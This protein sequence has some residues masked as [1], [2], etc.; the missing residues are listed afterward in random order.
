GRAM[1]TF[2][3]SFQIGA[4][5]GAIISGAL[6]DLVGFRGMYVGSIIITLAGVALLGAA[7]KS[8]PRPHKAASQP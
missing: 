4:G 3:I 2:S 7:W 6:A 5:A 1:A 8:L